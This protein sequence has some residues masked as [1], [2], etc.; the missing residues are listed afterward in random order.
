MKRQRGMALL[1]VLLV[2]TLALLLVEGLVRQQRVT[3]AATTVYLDTLRLRQALLD[4]EVRMLAELPRWKN[5]KP[6]VVHSRQP[7]A[8]PH[9]WALEDGTRLQGSITDL[10]GRFNLGWLARP[11]G[12]ARFERLVQALELTPVALPEGKLLTWREP[13]QARLLPGVTRPWLARF[14]P[15]VAWMPEAGRVNVN[16]V[17]APVLASLGIPLDIAR[18]LEDQAPAEGYATVQAWRGQPGLQGLPLQANDLAVGSRWFRLA[19]TARNGQR[20]LR[21]V[22][23]VELAASDGR[24]RVL[25]RWIRTI[26]DEAPAP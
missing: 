18:R 11:N 4:A 22:T 7:W 1:S 14:S 25:R 24:P 17:P 12:R 26:D 13:S 2:L 6:G 9:A 3:L 23:D 19:L 8:Q 20:R 5:S 16:T 21:L 15:Y 10:A